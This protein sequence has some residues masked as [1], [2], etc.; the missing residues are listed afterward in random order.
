L[1]GKDLRSITLTL[2]K[3]TEKVFT[4][5]LSLWF[6]QYEE[7]LNERATDLSESTK[8]PA[9]KHKKLRSAY[10]SLKTNL[11]YLFTYQKFPEL[12]IPNTTNSL[13]GSFSHLKNMVGIHRGK[14]RERRYKIIQEIL[15]KK[16]G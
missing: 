10:K 14:I 7:F 16:R 1:A 2:S 8:R 5:K 4:E 11:P 15:M 9:Y 3:T 6:N 13:D 12:H